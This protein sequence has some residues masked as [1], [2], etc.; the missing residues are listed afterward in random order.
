MNV[1]AFAAGRIVIAQQGQ[2]DL[3]WHYFVL[4]AARGAVRVPEHVLFAVVPA[5]AGRLGV[6]EETVE[7]EH[8]DR[9]LLLLP[10]S[11]DFVVERMARLMDFG[12][13]VAADRPRL[14]PEAA[15]GSFREP[16]S[17]TDLVHDA[18]LSL[19]QR[20]G[21]EHFLHCMDAIEGERWDARA[22]VA[23]MI[24]LLLLRWG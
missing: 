16:V 7:G 2:P 14:P 13:P 4:Q 9:A 3:P 11:P 23:A 17:Q 10:E 6:P 1:D 5:V 18:L 22:A 19:R 24:Y 20:Y 21:K 12:A 15:L 8:V